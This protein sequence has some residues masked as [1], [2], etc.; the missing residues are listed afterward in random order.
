M[1]NLTSKRLETLLSMQILGHISL[2][3]FFEGFLIAV[4]EVNPVIT[5]RAVEVSR[6][7]LRCT[8][9]GRL[10]QKS[11]GNGLETNQVFV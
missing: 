3:G 7:L 4:Y 6:C 11:W 9:I 10:Q 1:Q 5:H 2:R 8:Q